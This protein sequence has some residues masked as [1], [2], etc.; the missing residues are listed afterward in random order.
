M[1]IDTLLRA[2]GFDLLKSRRAI[3]TEQNGRLQEIRILGSDPEHPDATKMADFAVDAYG[4]DGLDFT[5]Q[6][7]LNAL[8]AVAQHF[9]VSTNRALDLYEIYITPGVGE[10]HGFIYA[11]PRIETRN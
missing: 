10:Y 11:R 8:H 4:D 7:R 6:A 1:I 2:A 3:R 5:A 9:D